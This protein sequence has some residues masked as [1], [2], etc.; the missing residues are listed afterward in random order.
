MADLNPPS[1]AR[2]P[3]EVSPAIRPIAPALEVAPQPTVVLDS[4]GRVC[5]A[6]RAA[7][8]AGASGDGV[9]A[10]AE[11]IAGGDSTFGAI[12]K[13]VQSEAGL[14][15]ILVQE[16]VGVHLRR[17]VGN[18]IDLEGDAYAVV[19]V[20]GEAEAGRPDSRGLQ[21]L[22]EDAM[23]AVIDA[24]SEAVLLFDGGGRC[25]LSNGLAQEATGY[26][27]GELGRLALA[28]LGFVKDE[29]E[30]AEALAA[31]EQR[32]GAANLRGILVTARGER[33]PVRAQ[34]RLLVGSSSR[35]VGLCSFSPP[36]VTSGRLAAVRQSGGYARPGAARATG[37]TPRSPASRAS[38]SGPSEALGSRASKPGSGARPVGA[39]KPGASAGGAPGAKHLGRSSSGARQAAPVAADTPPAER[40]A[41]APSGTAPAGRRA[42]AAS[43]SGGAGRP[44]VP[45]AKP[46]GMVAPPAPEAPDEPL[47]GGAGRT[48]PGR[49][50]SDLKGE[51]SQ[52][53][54]GAAAAGGVA[55]AFE[56]AESTLELD[57]GDLEIART[58]AP[59]PVPS[60]AE[61]ST[62]ISEIVVQLSASPSKVASVGVAIGS[63]LGYPATEVMSWTAEQWLE[64]VHQPALAD[65]LSQMWGGLVGQR[66]E[67]GA[68][69]DQTM[70][71]PL[72]RRDGQVVP[73][74]TLWRAVQAEDGMFQGLEIL[75]RPQGE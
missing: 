50:L 71:Y 61:K 69:P 1:V 56:G 38:D 2:L 20:Q 3:M 54:E 19:L 75:I 72:V 33:L 17:I 27:P 30:L 32:G 25:V 74:V 62:K 10:W 41:K 55:A 12:W 51:A 13:E 28:D 40:A 14:R 8:W 73:C 48:L 5:F 43:K 7:R 63:L 46:K 29:Q 35:V 4:Q 58:S 66:F 37:A 9:Q 49:P 59:P 11:G 60:P 52:G 53:G 26:P 57:E 64:R 34:V 24:S 15:E 22:R 67:P 65:Q 47:S 18:R 68:L 42:A 31:S 6:N 39:P 45:P 16:R 44:P 23:Q 70:E 21:S 36:R